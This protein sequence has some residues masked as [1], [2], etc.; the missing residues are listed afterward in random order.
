MTLSLALL[1]LL[2]ISTEIGRELCFK[3]GSHAE[4]KRG[5]LADIFTRPIVWLG[6]VQISLH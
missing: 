4:T 2:T 5:F 3:H 6:L 1:L